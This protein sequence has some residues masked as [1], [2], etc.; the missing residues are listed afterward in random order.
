LETQFD[1]TGVSIDFDRT[2]VDEFEKTRKNT[3]L[4]RDATKIDYADQPVKT[5]PVQYSSKWSVLYP[6]SIH[7]SFKIGFKT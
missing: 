4:C 1:W 6:P 5:R 3:V 2:K 7:R